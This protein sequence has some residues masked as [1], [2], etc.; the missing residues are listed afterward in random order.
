MAKIKDDSLKSG[1]VIPLMGILGFNCLQ[2]LDEKLNIE[3]IND[4]RKR[5]VDFLVKGITCYVI[6]RKYKLI[7]SKL[8]LFLSSSIIIKF[9]I[10][11]FIFPS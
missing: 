5:G 8:I 4:K 6:L 9:K 1:R 11:K 3:D 7:I 10:E 2:E